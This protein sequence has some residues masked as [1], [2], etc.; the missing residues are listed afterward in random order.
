MTNPNTESLVV[1]FKKEVARMREREA[2]ELEIQSMLEFVEQLIRWRGD[3]D[4]E[5]VINALREA[6][7]C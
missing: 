1:E 7:R 2:T 3:V 6:A 4:R 5:P